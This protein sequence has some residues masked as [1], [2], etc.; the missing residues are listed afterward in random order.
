M[1]LV[2]LVD[3]TSPRGNI[4]MPK[5]YYHRN[6]KGTVLL[7]KISVSKLWLVGAAVL[8]TMFTPYCTI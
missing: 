4:I 1:S 7:H 2:T 6:G 3:E 8:W 5:K